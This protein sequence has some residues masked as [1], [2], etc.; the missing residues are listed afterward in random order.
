MFMGYL[1]EPQ[2]TMAT[3]TSDGWLKSGDLGY[4]DKV[5]VVGPIVHRSVCDTYVRVCVRACVRVCVCA[6]EK[7][8]DHNVE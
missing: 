8:I 2:V 4:I 6:W 7:H 3:F 1:G 5:G